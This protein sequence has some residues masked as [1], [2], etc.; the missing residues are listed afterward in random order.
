MLKIL[1][2]FLLTTLTFSYAATTATSDP[3][4][5]DDETASTRK[6]Q[7]GTSN[8]LLQ[9]PSLVK[10][11]A[12]HESLSISY[13]KRTYYSAACYALRTALFL[14]EYVIAPSI[15]ACFSTIECLVD[16]MD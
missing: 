7:P 11:H 1:S 16:C 13:L 14:L 3:Y 4:E 9:T 2:V 12:P 8:N 10:S 15:S 6:A 5:G